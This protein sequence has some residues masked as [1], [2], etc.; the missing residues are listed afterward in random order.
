MRLVTIGELAPTASKCPEGA[1]ARRLPFAWPICLQ[2]AYEAL[3]RIRPK[4]ASC[5]Q[6]GHNHAILLGWLLDHTQ[7]SDAGLEHLMVLTELRNITLSDTQVTEK[8][9]ARLKG[10]L[11]KLQGSLKGP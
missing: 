11:P 4:N 5:L 7:V 2:C 9:F 10:A 3:N 1:S 8:G 6:K